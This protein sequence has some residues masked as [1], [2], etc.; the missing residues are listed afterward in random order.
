MNLNIRKNQPNY[1]EI[2]FVDEDVAI[3]SAIKEKVIANKDVEFA[4]AKHEHPQIGHPVL[5]VRTQK[6]KALDLVLEA[7]DEIE[8]ETEEFKKAIKSAKK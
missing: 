8:K 3:P 7:I 2:E 1:I 5:V 6:E 4:S